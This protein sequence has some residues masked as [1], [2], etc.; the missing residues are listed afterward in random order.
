LLFCDRRQQAPL[1]HCS[2][3]V[4]GQSAGQMVVTGSCET[5]DADLFR[6]A[7]AHLRSRRQFAERLQGGSNI[8]SR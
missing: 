3:Y 5:Q 8:R 2:M 6:F 4:D 7:I 1:L